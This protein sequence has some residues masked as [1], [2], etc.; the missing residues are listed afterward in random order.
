MIRRFKNLGFCTWKINIIN[1][2]KNPAQLIPC[3]MLKQR[4]EKKGILI[5]NFMTCSSK[6]NPQVSQV[7]IAFELRVKEALHEMSTSAS[8]CTCSQCLPGLRVRVTILRKSNGEVSWLRIKVISILLCSLKRKK[9]FSHINS[10]RRG[11]WNCSNS[12]F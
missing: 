8:F 10:F 3:D 9:M 1:N 7:K 11:V 12:Y 6:Q 5:P 4:E 2:G